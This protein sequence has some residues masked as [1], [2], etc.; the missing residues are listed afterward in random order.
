MRKVIR[1]TPPA[2]QADIDLYATIDPG[3]TNLNPVTISNCLAGANNSG[4][5]VGP[6]GTE[7]VFFTNSHPGEVY[8]VGVKSEDQ[9]ASEFDFIAIFTATPFST[10]QP[11]GDQLVNGLLLPSFVPDGSPAM[12][13]ITNV[14]ALAITP[15]TVA[16]VIVTNLNQHQNFGDLVG[17]LSCPSGGTSV[18]NNHDGDGNTYNT[19]IPLVYDDSANPIRGSRH[20]DGPGTMTGFQGK[21]GVGPWILT[22]VDN[23]L[24]MTGQVS[25]FNLLIQP[26]RDLTGGA[27][28]S[29]PPDSWFIDFVDVPP[30]YTNLT[31]Y[32]TNLPPIFF[33]PN[34]L[35]MYEKFNAAPTFTDFD[36][37][38]DLTNTLFPGADPG[39]SISI[40][41]PLDIGRYFIGIFNSSSNVSADCLHSGPVGH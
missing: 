34:Q 1:P 32:S 21:S 40:G 17:T 10:I 35:K 41:P 2:L 24:T 5:S 33:P 37:E 15:M 9:M 7:F 29:I 19:V 28:V 4:A 11:N 8:Y 36:F 18:L 13:G 31:F 25:V 14:F 27:I 20:T 12:P 26:H 6:L 16:N 39:N 30:G 22:E 38:A 3:L 23:S